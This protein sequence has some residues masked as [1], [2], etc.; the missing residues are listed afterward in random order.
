MLM[1]HLIKRT[2][3]SLTNTCTDTVFAAYL[4]VHAGFAADPP[5]RLSEDI[6]LIVL[7]SRYVLPNNIRGIF[8]RIFEKIC[9]K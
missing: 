7:G 1:V 6:P 9:C 8:F 2:H 5:Y 3:F 4:V